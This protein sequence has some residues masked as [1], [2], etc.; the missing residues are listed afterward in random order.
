MLWFNHTGA[1]LPLQEPLTGRNII[2]N[3]SINK[4][5]LLNIFYMS[6]ILYTLFYVILQSRG[7]PGPFYRCG[8]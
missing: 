7:R 6:G 3:R 2:I 1:E 8:N 4:S 5:Q